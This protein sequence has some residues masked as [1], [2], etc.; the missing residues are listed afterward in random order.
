MQTCVDTSSLLKQC[1]IQYYDITI[2]QK[3]YILFIQV[4]DQTKH[5]SST[6]GMQTCVDTS[7]LLKQCI[8]Q[9]YDITIQV[10]YILFI[11]VIDQTKHTSST[12]GMQTCVDT[13]SLLKQRVTTI[14]E[15]E[16]KITQA[17]IDCDFQTFAEITMRVKISCK[18]VIGFI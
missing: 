5:T 3:L 4:S 17:L 1:I 18:D 12:D 8:I 11:Q 15:K 6:D 7:S 2:Q 16:E 14:P 9:Y 13:S 10:I